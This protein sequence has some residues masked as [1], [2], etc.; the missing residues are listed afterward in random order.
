MRV[1]MLCGCIDACVYMCVCKKENVCVKMQ[2]YNRA[3]LSRGF[4]LWV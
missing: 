3:S 1:C 2:L 4:R